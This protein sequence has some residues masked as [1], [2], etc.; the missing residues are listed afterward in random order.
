MFGVEEVLQPSGEGV[1][2]AFDGGVERV[3]KVNESA[4]G[5]ELLLDFLA[6]DDLAGPFQQQPQY[7]E[8]LL[9]Q[10]DS[11]PAFPQLSR[12]YVQF[13]YTEANWP[14]GW[15]GAPHISS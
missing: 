12:W 10:L 9:L 13:K 14:G 6:G 2:E 15:R 8:G 11:N 7:L 4:V 1:A 5:P 3:F